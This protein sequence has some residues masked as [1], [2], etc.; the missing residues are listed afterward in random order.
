MC[1]KVI[2]I[3]Q[4]HAIINNDYKKASAKI[5]NLDIMI[6]FIIYDKRKQTIPALKN[7]TLCYWNGTANAYLAKISAA[8]FASS[9]VFVWPIEQTEKLL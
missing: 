7:P 2:V 4:F 8:R 3:L 9:V 6:A 5:F 1:R